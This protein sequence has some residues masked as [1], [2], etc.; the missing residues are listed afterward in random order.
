MNKQDPK[1]TEQL[2]DWINT[3]DAQKNWDE[4]AVLLLQLSGNKIMYRNISVNPKG[5]AEFIKGQLQKYLNFRLQ[6]L[7]KDQVSDMQSQV[8]EIVKSVIKPAATVPD[9]SA[10]GKSAEFADFKAGKR[11]DHD[12][13]PA[14]IQALYVENLD[15]INRMRELHLKL[16]TMS[17]D[18]ATCPDSERYPFLKEI[19]ALDKKRVENWDIY[20]HFIPGTHVDEGAAAPEP[21]DE[22]QA[23][24]TE[25]TSVN[26]EGLTEN[27]ADTSDNPEGVTEDA[28]VKDEQSAPVE[29]KP[30]KAKA[31]A[32]RTTKK[33]SKK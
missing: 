31:T 20:D 3:P 25:E 17:L 30:K 12:S 22:G 8:D 23:D 32:K 19:I 15:I 18:D 27:P 4:G 2:Q 9:G 29:A 24:E 21:E 16:R 5:K 7:T 26:S 33:A 6:Q 13:L 28:A 14:E 10:S 1:F 11:E